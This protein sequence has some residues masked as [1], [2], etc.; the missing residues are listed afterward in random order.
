MKSLNY[1]L[2]V[3]LCLIILLLVHVE[4]G[5]AK[6]HKHHA[7]KRRPTKHHPKRPAKKTKRPTKFPTRIHITPAPTRRPTCPAG[8][9]V[10]CSPPRT[11][12]T[13]CC[14]PTVVGGND[15]CCLDDSTCACHDTGKCPINNFCCPGLAPVTCQST[16]KI[17]YCCPQGPNGTSAVCCKDTASCAFPGTTTCCPPT[18]PLFCLAGD[19]LYCCP[20]LPNGSNL[21]CCLESRKC[22][23]DGT[24]PASPGARSAN[25]ET[26]ITAIVAAL[27]GPTEAIPATRAVAN[28]GR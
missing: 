26:P 8:F 2:V 10:K 14:Q 9:P 5:E 25:A 19:S 28:H 27:F 21:V 17:T 3:T 4:I 20:P 22:S 13:Y 23:K 16:T 11:G 7:H 15:V 24:C 6:P 12:F 18:T 1:I